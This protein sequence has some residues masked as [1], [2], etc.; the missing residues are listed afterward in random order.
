MAESNNTPSKDY[1]APLNI[2]WFISLLFLLQ[3]LTVA[4]IKAQI[5]YISPGIEL[6]YIFGQGFTFSAEVTLGICIYLAHGSIALGHQLIPEKP[7]SLS[8]FA[9]QGGTLEYGASIGGVSYNDNGT[10]E[11]GSRFAIYYGFPLSWKLGVV[12]PVIILSSKLLDFPSLDTRYM[13]IGIWGKL[14]TLPTAV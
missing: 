6:G 7:K 9:V 10:E 14:L 12:N 2:R 1:R 5:P 13:S 4:P 3:I 11:T 8:Y